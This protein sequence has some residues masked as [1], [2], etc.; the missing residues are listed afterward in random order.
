LVIV[1][2]LFDPRKGG[3]YSEEILFKALQVQS[4]NHRNARTSPYHHIFNPDP[5]KSPKAEDWRGLRASIRFARSS[6]PIL[7]QW[8]ISLYGPVTTRLHWAYNW[9][10]ST[11]TLPKLI[12]YD[13]PRLILEAD[14][15]PSDRDEALENA[16]NVLRELLIEYSPSSEAGRK[17]VEVIMSQIRLELDKEEDQVREQYP[18]WK[19]DPVSAR[20][21]S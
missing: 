14:E 18:W 13:I 6:N 20:V 11:P 9:T 19:P 8:L 5:S 10:N 21:T 4:L 16:N 2:H 17:Q 15:I 1:W 3:I 12:L 7:A